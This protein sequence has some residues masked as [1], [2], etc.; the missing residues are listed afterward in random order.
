MSSEKPLNELNNDGL[1]TTNFL[2]CFFELLL[3]YYLINSL[4]LYSFYFDYFLSS[5]II[6]S[7]LVS[8]ST[9]FSYKNKLIMK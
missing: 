1:E 3:D 5:K 8:Y 7:V 9:F 6:S 2:S 4:R